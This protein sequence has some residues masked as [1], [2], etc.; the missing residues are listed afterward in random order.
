M[1]KGKAESDR[2]GA[3][4]GLAAEREKEKIEEDWRRSYGEREKATQEEKQ[5]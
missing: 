2:E 5:L 3:K 4:R 1:E